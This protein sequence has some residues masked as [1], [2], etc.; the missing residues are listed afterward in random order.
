[1]NASYTIGDKVRYLGVETGSDSPDFEQEGHIVRFIYPHEGE[2]Q[3]EVKFENG[4]TFIAPF[5]MWGDP[6][7][8]NALLIGIGIAVV[9]VGGYFW[10]RSLARANTTEQK[11][12]N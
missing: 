7:K 9:L 4:E 1:M 3:Y 8:S 2:T 11:T 10:I 6:G 12:E 5:D